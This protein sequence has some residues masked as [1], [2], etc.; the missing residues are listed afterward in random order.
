[1][2][3]VCSMKPILKFM[4]P[5]KRLMEKCVR[6]VSTQVKAQGLIYRV[7]N[8]LFYKLMLFFKHG[9]LSNTRLTQEDQAGNFGNFLEGKKKRIVDPSIFL[10]WIG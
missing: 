5:K 4:T 3:M 9:T 8:L 7:A 1:M 10:F 2:K 6:L